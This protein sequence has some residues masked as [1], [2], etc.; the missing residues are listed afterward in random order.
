MIEFTVNGL[1]ARDNIASSIQPHFPFTTLFLHHSSQ[2]VY[3]RAPHL[4]LWIPTPIFIT[5]TTTIAQVIV[6]E[7]RQN[8][9]LNV[10]KSMVKRGWKQRNDQSVAMFVELEKSNVSNQRER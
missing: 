4:Q 1:A 3:N 8:L 6:E 7:I 9:A 2:P 5:H 10:V